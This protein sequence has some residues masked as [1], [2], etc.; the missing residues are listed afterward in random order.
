MDTQIY[1]FRPTNLK[2]TLATITMVSCPL[3]QLPDDFIMTPTTHNP[4]PTLDNE[5]DTISL[6]TCFNKPL[7]QISL[8]EKFQFDPSIRKGN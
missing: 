2:F 5:K 7:T 1:R 8:S 4:Q 6:S 3:Q